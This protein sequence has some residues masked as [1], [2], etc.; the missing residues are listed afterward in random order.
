LCQGNHKEKHEIRS[1]LGLQALRQ[2]KL[3]EFDCRKADCGICLVKVLS[4][5]E[6]AISAPQHQELDFLK[7]MHAE[8]DE[9][10]GCQLRIFKD[11]VLEVPEP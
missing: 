4:A 1:G 9:R 7:A 3:V 10:L 6:G 8:P 5:P 11:V 2:Q